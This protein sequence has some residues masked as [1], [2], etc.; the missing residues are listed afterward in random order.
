VERCGR[1]RHTQRWWQLLRV[2]VALT[3]AGQVVQLLSVHMPKYN[4]HQLSELGGSR[5]IVFG[6]V[7]LFWKYSRIGLG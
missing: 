5:R 6:Q 2:G 3:W 7:G 4:Y 1:L